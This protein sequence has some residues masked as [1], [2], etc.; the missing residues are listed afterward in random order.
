MLMSVEFVPESTLNTPTH[1][2]FT[3]LIT[4]HPQI[5]LHLN[6][7]KNYNDKYNKKYPE[8]RK[9]HNK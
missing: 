3:R 6:K 1:E 7:I 4:R 8:N 9:K 5:N 2:I